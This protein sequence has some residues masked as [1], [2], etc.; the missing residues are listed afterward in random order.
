MLIE[1]DLI[2]DMYVC[3]TYNLGLMENLSEELR[4][5]SER[6]SLI[7]FTTIFPTVVLNALPFK[8]RMR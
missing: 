5:Y 7:K 6:K 2:C 1:H 4:L 8:P 3:L